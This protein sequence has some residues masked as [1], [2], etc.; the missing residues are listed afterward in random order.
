MD[1]REHPTVK[2]RLVHNP[3]HEPADDGANYKCRLLHG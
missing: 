3:K 2:R 1:L